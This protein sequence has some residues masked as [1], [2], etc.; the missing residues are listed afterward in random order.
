MLKKKDT[1]WQKFSQNAFRRSD[2]YWLLSSVYSQ[3]PDESFIEHIN[4]SSLH[5]ILAGGGRWDKGFWTQP[6]QK[7][8]ED[9]AVEYTRL[10]LGPKNHIPP[11]ESLYNY[12]E[13]EVRQ[14][15]GSA[16]VEVKRIIE[17]S[18]LSFREDYGS[19][20]DH[21]CI[22]MEFM[23]KLVK[24]EAQLWEEQ[25]YDSQLD[26]TIELEKK[27]ID[28]HLNIWI[29]DF[30]QKVME[31]SKMDFYRNFAEFTIDFIMNEKEEVENL[32]SFFA[33]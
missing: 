24:K 5:Q 16:T 28:E 11:F 7:I 18:G 1:N 2:T 17:S 19:I 13:G 31:A 33:E 15:W 4:S 9:L 25:K 14:I 21:I 12:K 6:V 32:L 26:R 23:Q 8:S 27:F 20:P 22:E 29:P 30:C 10:F 3:E